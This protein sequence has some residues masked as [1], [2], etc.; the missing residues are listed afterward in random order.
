MAAAGPKELSSAEA[1]TVLRALDGRLRGGLPIFC[2]L[3]LLVVAA[4]MIA[5]TVVYVAL[6]GAAIGGAWWCATYRFEPY[7][8][9]I[10]A[11]LLDLVLHAAALLAGAAMVF[12]MVK[13]LLAPVR[14]GAP[15]RALKPDEQ[16]VLFDYVRRLCAL[17]NAPMPR[18][19]EINCEVNAAASLRS[20]FFGSLGGR[21]LT[22][23]IGLPLAGALNL[24]Q[25]TGVLAHEFGHTGQ[26]VTMRFIRSV[27][28]W[29]ARVV[30]E[31]DAWDDWL[32]RTILNPDFRLRPLARFTVVFDWLTRRILWLLMTAAN[33]ISSFAARQ[34]EYAADRIAARVVGSRAVADALLKLRP[35]AIAWQRSISDLSH[36][37]VEKRLGDNLPAL[38]NHN[39]G[40][41]N[42]ALRGRIQIEALKE[43][44]GFFSTH[45]ALCQRLRRLDKLADAGL[46]RD[47]R[48]AAARLFCD[49]DALC[50]DVS[51]DVYAA[52]IGPAVVHS[53]L[54][55]IAELIGRRA[56][57]VDG[58]AA[59][60]EFCFECIL[61]TRM[62][63]PDPELIERAPDNPRAVAAELQRARD[64]V[65]QAVAAIRPACARYREGWQI[66]LEAFAFEEQLRAG[67]QARDVSEEIVAEKFE[68][69]KR[70]TVQAKAAMAPF[71]DATRRRMEC[72]LLLL[73]TPQIRARLT[74]APQMLEQALR[75]AAAIEAMRGL[76]ETIEEL[77]RAHQGLS[78]LLPCAKGRAEDDTLRRRIRA[79][80]SAVYRAVDALYIRL[81]STPYPFEHPNGNVSI[82]V[83]TVD[84]PPPRDDTAAVLNK[85]QV[86]LEALDRLYARCTGALARVCID[87]EAALGLPPI[88]E[89]GPDDA[90]AP[91]PVSSE[92]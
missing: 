18:R 42:G 92:D 44:S 34:A 53:T 85:G 47:E 41:M 50:R 9:N 51:M 84:V 39:F 66:L 74:E 12:F 46:L 62:I 28:V 15:S 73:H 68:V 37:W 76:G 4:A 3:V 6:I 21:N 49:F 23:R 81:K 88:S 38:I 27:N 77:I 60:R 8:G 58:Y 75:V 1:Q 56:E 63:G 31:R 57:V 48:T 13:P 71:Q 10:Y 43:R 45:P 80:R 67:I 86:V 26:A 64:G 40:Q 87:V 36:A 25:F 65:R 2:H 33:L 61:F 19:I 32:F 79:L 54:V 7:H 24:R 55:P 78:A 82:G 72:A 11:F 5:L 70:L 89:A 91:P 83:V 52:T 69:G 16:P 17:T 35:L 30:Y 90:G 59:L 29:L 14:R 22:L 20:G